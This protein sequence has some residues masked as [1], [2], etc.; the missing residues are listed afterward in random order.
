MKT[1]LASFPDTTGGPERRIGSRRVLPG[2]AAYALVSASVGLGLFASLTP[3]PLYETYA[4]LWHFSVLTLT[5]VYA[6]YA[7]GVLAT[8]LLAGGASDQIGRRPVLL[9]S[10]CLLMISTVFYMVADSVAWL[11]VARGLQGLATGAVLSSASAAMIDFHPRRDAAGVGIMNGVMSAI[12]IALGTVISSSLV[13]AGTAPRVLPYVVVLVL[14]A[15]ASLGV[16]YLPEPVTERTNFRFTPQKPSVPPAVRRPFFLAALA[17]LSS[18]SIGGLFFS[19]GPQ[20]TNLLFHSTNTVVSGVGIVMLAGSAAVASLPVRRLAPRLAASIG[21][22]GL[23]VGMV[24]IVLAVARSSAG[25]FIAGSILA[26]FGF[27]MAFL[28]GLRGLVTVIP[29]ETRGAVMAAFYIAAYASLSVPA[30]LAGV[31]VPHLGLQ[32][33]FE[34][35]GSIVA[36]IALIVAE[37]AFR[38]RV[39]TA[40]PLNLSVSSARKAA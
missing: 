28:G 14:F 8:L 27:G 17:V 16:A 24:L 19:L 1:V 3:S 7:F 9:A 32:P 4:R 38:V 21:S 20:L 35:F 10:L 6:T 15:V 39:S 37:E 26:G 34:V 5:L 18:W 36:G 11:F 13:Q 25:Y 2:R 12:G 33:T 30:V 22:V 23:A 40:R 31:V 29:N